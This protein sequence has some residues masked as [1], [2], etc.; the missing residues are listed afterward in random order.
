M[1]REL[2]L[3]AAAAAAAA[4]AAAGFYALATQAHQPSRLVHAVPC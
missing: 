1:V 2:R 4:V 3:W